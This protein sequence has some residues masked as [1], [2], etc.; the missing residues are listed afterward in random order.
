MDY[1][2]SF[3]KSDN[4]LYQIMA[5][6]EE[7]EEQFLAILLAYPSILGG[8]RD[9]Y[10]ARGR[11]DW[12]EHV[13]E[14]YAEGDKAFFCLYRM[15]YSSYMKLVRLIDPSVRKNGAMAEIRTG[16]ECGLI[17][18][19]IALHCCLR[20]LAG[21]SYLDVRLSARISPAS[22]YEYAHRCFTA[23]NRCEELIY[24]F[25]STPSEIDNAALGFRS[26]SSHGVFKGCVAAVDG[27]LL[28]TNQ[29]PSKKVGNV[30][31]YYSGHYRTHGINVIAA[32]DHRCKFVFMA[33]N[34][35]GGTNDARAYRNC[36]L[37]SFVEDLPVGKF[38]I[39]DAA[40]TVGE[41][42]LTPF[43]GGSRIRREND[44]YNYFLSQLRI[45]IEMTFGR[46]MNKWR[47]FC[48]PLSVSILNVGKMFKTATILH[49]FYIDEKPDDGVDRDD[50]DVDGTDPL[51]AE[52]YIQPRV[53]NTR[54]SSYMRA[55]MVER[56]KGKSL[57]RPQQNIA[58]NGRRYLNNSV[59]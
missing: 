1:F 6:E 49:N 8:Q 40:Y 53:R 44:T 38:I 30:N 21:G 45:R 31:S 7:E 54:G 24:H 11:M 32:C 41:H 17:T 57:E 34:S 55:I 18:T 46:C 51:P 5:E 3:Q 43:S 14:L 12:N 47:L 29:P 4:V 36:S 35:P 50:H 59:N 58:R 16:T 56:I 19:E 26:I 25:P 15:E 9:S 20:W 48:T 27:L 10:Y 28:R 42:L 37:P 23:I 39:G 52:Y 22:F 13:R 33:A 2:Y